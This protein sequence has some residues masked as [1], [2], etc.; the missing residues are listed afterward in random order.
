MTPHEFAVPAASLDAAGRSIP[1]CVRAS[2]IHGALEGNEATDAGK[3]GELDVRLSKSGNDVVVHGR[4]TASLRA[5]C[6]R[7]L[8]PVTIHVD[9]PLSV[10]MVPTARIKD[11]K[12]NEYEI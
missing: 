10:L 2:W 3:D 7:C 12:S 8:E 5:P 4:L 11:P 1:F 9:E 6:A